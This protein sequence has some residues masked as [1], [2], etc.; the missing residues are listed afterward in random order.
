MGVA[1]TPPPPPCTGEGYIS[2]TV[3]TVNV[4]K[5]ILQV[6]GMLPARLISDSTP[7]VAEICQ[8]AVR[9]IRWLQDDKS[10]TERLTD[11]PYNSVDPM[12]PADELS[13][14]SCA[15]AAL[16]DN[17]QSLLER[18]RAIFSLRNRQDAESVTALA[19]GLVPPAV[20]QRPVPPRDRLRAG[21]GGPPGPYFTKWIYSVSMAYLFT[22]GILLHI[23][24]HQ[25]PY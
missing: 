14:L 18:Y 16:L 8:L 23:L 25:T 10:Q 17:K 21:P 9:R 22:F 1:S 4:V 6:I 24:F 19:D 11:N 12:P 2:C 5:I 20:R 7:E 15:E 3:F 13:R